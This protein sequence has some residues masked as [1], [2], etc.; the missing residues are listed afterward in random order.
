V[1][2]A[3][4]IEL[5]RDM[6]EEIDIQKLIYTLYVRRKIEM[7]DADAAAGREVTQEEF[8]RHTDAWHAGSTLR[9]G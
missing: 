5:I 3:D 7:G 1:K 9:D 6:P 2:K 4:V 8:E